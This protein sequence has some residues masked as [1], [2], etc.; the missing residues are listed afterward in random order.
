MFDFAKFDAR[1]VL[2]V[3]DLMLHEVVYGRTRSTTST[4]SLVAHKWE[5]SVA[6]SAGVAKWVAALG[7]QSSIVAPVGDDQGACSVRELLGRDGISLRLVR[8]TERSTVRT[9]R[10]VTDQAPPILTVER[11][12]RNPVRGQIEESLL[13]RIIGEVLDADVIVLSDHDCGALT[14]RLIRDTI[15]AAR[16]QGIPTL[17]VSS[18]ADFSKYAGATILAPGFAH[19][20]ASIGSVPANADELEIVSLQVLERASIEALLVVQPGF[21]MSFIP[22]ATTATHLGGFGIADAEFRCGDA[23]IAALALALACGL[24]WEQAMEACYAAASSALENGSIL[25]DALRD[26]TTIA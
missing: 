15:A 3:G 2:C 9:I 6:G 5:V 23:G 14:D 25:L 19:L 22:R 26:G 18:Q 1:K 21:G 20:C 17:V 24:P 12:G 11:E 7:A 10:Y 13:A 4:P 16:Q 8:D